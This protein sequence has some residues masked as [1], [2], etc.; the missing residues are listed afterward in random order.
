VQ[1]G[2]NEAAALGIPH[3]SQGASKDW[4]CKNHISSKCG[5]YRVA[6]TQP[7]G[8][9]WQ[10]PPKSFQKHIYLLDTSTS[11]NHF[12]PPENISWL[13]SWVTRCFSHCKVINTCC[14][15]LMGTCLR[16]A[17]KCMLSDLR[18]RWSTVFGLHPISFPPFVGRPIPA[19]LLLICGLL[20]FK[21]SLGSLWGL[22]LKMG[23]VKGS[24]KRRE[25]GSD[26][27]LKI[28]NALFLIIIRW[29]IIISVY[30]P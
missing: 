29:F 27:F 22:G 4:S 20:V 8:P 2:S 6:G 13:H 5:S 11:Y 17:C 10:L 23:G 24:Q 9:T 7:E 3:P 1:R 26:I 30:T 21:L 16:W 15:D 28:F 12:A 25:Y 18:E 14:M 19:N